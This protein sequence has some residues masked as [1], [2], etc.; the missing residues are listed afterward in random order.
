MQKWVSSFCNYNKS[1]KKVG[2]LEIELDRQHSYSIFRFLVETM[3][4]IPEA[5]Q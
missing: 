5:T 3:D 1:V 2:M 4:K